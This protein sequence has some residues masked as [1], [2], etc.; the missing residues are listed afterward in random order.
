MGI[1]LFIII[2]FLAGLIARAL[3]PGP[4]HMGVIATT[5]VGMAGSLLGGFIGSLLWSH[6]QEGWLHPA[7]IIMSIIGALIVLAIYLA[8]TRRHRVVVP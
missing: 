1:L 5:L 8:A 7:G 6:G 2:G 4:Q 3:M